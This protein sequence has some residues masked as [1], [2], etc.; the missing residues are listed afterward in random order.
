[1]YKA[2]LLDLN[3][4]LSEN[5]RKVGVG[6]YTSEDKIRS[7]ERYRAWLADWLRGVDSKVYIFTVRPARTREATLE[8]IYKRLFWKP[9]G[10]YFND[11]PYTGN[12]ADK[13]KSIL[14]DRLMDEAG[15]KPED[16]YAFESNSQARAMYNR[17]GV[18]C[19]RIGEPSHLPPVSWFRKTV[20][21]AD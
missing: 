4:T 20:L 7:I 11:T 8:T 17:R 21:E 10:A 15:L 1:M 3:S 14:L 13:V 12:N 9:D 18:Q 5:W 2:I 6:R 16:L 19:R